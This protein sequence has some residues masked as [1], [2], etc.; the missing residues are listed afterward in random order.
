MSNLGIGD[1][2]PGVDA[3]KGAVVSSVP[4][5]AVIVLFNVVDWLVD[6]VV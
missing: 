6:P 5:D 4:V 3:S 1:T 2:A